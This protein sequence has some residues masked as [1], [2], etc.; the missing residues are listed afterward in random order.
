MPRLPKLRYLASALL[1]FLVLLDGCRSFWAADI[2]Q[3]TQRQDDPAS[4]TFHWQFIATARGYLIF[5]R[6]TADFDP[7]WRE[8]LPLTLGTDYTLSSRVEYSEFDEIPPQKNFLGFAYGPTRSDKLLGTDFFAFSGTALTI[9]FWFLAS[10]TALPCCFGG[11][12]AIRTLQRKRRQKTN[13][14]LCIQCNYDLRAQSIGQK[15]PEC[16]TVKKYHY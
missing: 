14:H 7:S 1:T 11:W 6:G 10:L 16:G 15:C 8:R 4:I 3:Q 2:V 5:Y 9:P 12:K 13:P